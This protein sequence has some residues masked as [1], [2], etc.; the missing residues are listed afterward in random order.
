MNFIDETGNRH[1]RLTVI[2]RSKSDVKA[3]WL[4]ECECGNKTIVVGTQLRNGHTRSCGCLQREAAAKTA[5]GNSKSKKHGMYKTKEYHCWLNLKTRCYRESYR[6]Y[7]HYGG[8]GISVCDRWL[9]NF[10]NFYTDMGPRP[11]DKHSIDR[12]NV[13]GNY[14]PSNCRWTTRSKQNANKRKVGSISSFTTTE[15]IEE[16]NI[17]GVTI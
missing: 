17:R 7:Q 8:R 13:N 4:C 3:F 14:E 6:D 10:E 5:P 15:L 11:S 1:G 2:E 9:K 16:L 12:I